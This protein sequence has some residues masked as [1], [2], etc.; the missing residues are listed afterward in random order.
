MGTNISCNNCE[1][2]STNYK[3]IYNNRNIDNLGEVK[4]DYIYQYNFASEEIKKVYSIVGNINI[5]FGIRI[6]MEQFLCLNCYHS[7]NFNHL[8]KEWGM[9]SFYNEKGYVKIDFQ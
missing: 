8:P 2:K 5:K 1:N 9:E 6:R 7:I 3:V 4:Y